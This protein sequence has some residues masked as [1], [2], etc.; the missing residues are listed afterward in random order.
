MLAETFGSELHLVDEWDLLRRDLDGTAL[1]LTVR[2]RF[3]VP[4]RS[5]QERRPILLSCGR[6]LARYLG[7]QAAGGVRVV[8]IE[9]LHDAS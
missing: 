2:I 8:D 4:D 9:P 7:N 1:P 5:S 3:L 6:Y